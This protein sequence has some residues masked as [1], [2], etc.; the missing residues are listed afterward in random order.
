[1]SSTFDTVLLD[2]G[3]LRLE[4][5]AF[6]FHGRTLSSFASEDEEWQPLCWWHEGE[7]A[8]QSLP[9]QPAFTGPVFSH[10][11]GLVVHFQETEA[12]K[13]VE[14]AVAEVSLFRYGT[15]HRPHL[16]REDEADIAYL[17]VGDYWRRETG[18]RDLHADRVV[19]APASFFQP[20]EAPAVVLI[21][22]VRSRLSPLALGRQGC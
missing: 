4:S 3:S 18:G 6:A 12:G 21:P 16:R 2:D 1:V 15:E 8:W 11:A 22:H 17:Q 5:P 7:R 20:Q 13:S 10:A 9:G 14:L 19:I